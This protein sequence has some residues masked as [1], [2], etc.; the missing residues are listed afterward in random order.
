MGIR[1]HGSN[2]ELFLHRRHAAHGFTLVEALVACV[3]LGVTCITTTQSLNV[4][5]NRAAVARLRVNAQA[6]AQRNLTAALNAPFSATQVPA[7]LGLTGTAGAVYDDDNNGDGKVNLV[8]QD[9]GG[10]SVITGVLTRTVRSIA[11]S[12]GADIRRVTFRVDYSYRGRTYSY[13]VQT[14]RTRT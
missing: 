1:A 14:V 8:V 4:S 6:V 10:P 9:N 5:N 3:L 13:E 7:V 12:E 11:N 2:R